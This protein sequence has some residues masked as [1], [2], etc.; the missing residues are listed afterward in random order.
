MSVHEALVLTP[1]LGALR[2]RGEVEAYLHERSEVFMVSG[3]PYLPVLRWHL[4]LTEAT[5]ALS[6]DIIG[7]WMSR[8]LS[9]RTRYLA[10][11]WEAGNAYLIKVRVKEV[12]RMLD[13]IEARIKEDLYNN[14]R[15]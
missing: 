1:S 6:R 8:D 14:L 13:E 10:Q 5:M 2:Y 7:G 12:R 11:A 4:N 15:S 3:P 9:D